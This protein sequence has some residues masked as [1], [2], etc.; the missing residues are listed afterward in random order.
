MGMIR[1]R[2]EGV[3][4]SPPINHAELSAVGPRNQV[5]PRACDPVVYL[6]FLAT[7][8]SIRT[9]SSFRTV[10][11]DVAMFMAPKALDLADVCGALICS[12]FL[13]TTRITWMSYRID[14]FVIKFRQIIRLWNT[15]VL[16]CT[17][18]RAVVY[19]YH[20]QRTRSTMWS[21]YLTGVGLKCVR[22]RCILMGAM[23]ASA[24]LARQGVE[25]CEPTLVSKAQHS[26]CPRQLTS[27][28][29]NKLSDSECL[30]N[31]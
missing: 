13:T 8:L 16:K 1:S 10:L 25:A 29:K 11:R 14:H 3:L 30:F 24:P 18:E 15:R 27:W 31:F 26:C 23:A 12:V 4:R 22:I 7:A 17:F 19:V 2:Y 5:R 21:F 6:C 20:L 9:L 28:R